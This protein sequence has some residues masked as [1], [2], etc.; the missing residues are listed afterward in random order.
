M[1]HPLPDQRIEYSEGG[2][3]QEHS[4]EA[5]ESAAHHNG[6]QHPDGG[7][8]G[9]VT[10]DLGPQDVAVKL[11]EGQHQNGKAQRRPGVHNDQNHDTG[12]SS[13]DGAKEGDH[14]GDADDN[15]DEDIIGDLKNQVEDEAE[16][17][18]DGGVNELSV[19]KAHKDPIC[20]TA[21]AKEPGR[22]L[23]GDGGVDKLKGLLQETNPPR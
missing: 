15:G 1:V 22:L 3:A 10:Q 11:L 17:A 12:N 23:F 6:Y 13:D 5:E 4:G 16:H 14:V 8:A 18:N 20:L 19:D 21:Y 7:K 2:H 9:A